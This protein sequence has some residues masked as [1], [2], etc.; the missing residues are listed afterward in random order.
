[1]YVWRGQ[2]RI[3]VNGNPLD[4]YFGDLLMR[5]HVLKPLNVVGLVDQVDVL[6]QVSDPADVWDGRAALTKLLYRAEISPVTKLPCIMLSVALYC[7]LHLC[8]TLL[9]H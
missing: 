4:V 3:L 5:S 7:N 6:V 9:L 8:C 1:V 2:G